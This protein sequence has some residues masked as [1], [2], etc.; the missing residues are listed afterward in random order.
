MVFSRQDRRR[1]RQGNEN[2]D[3]SY[4][5]E[6][7]CSISS[8][9]VAPTRLK[10]MAPFR[11][12]ARNFHS[13]QYRRKLYRP[14]SGSRPRGS[15]HPSKPLRIVGPSFPQNSRSA[16]WPISRSGWPFRTT[17]LPNRVCSNSQKR[18]QLAYHSTP[19]QDSASSQAAPRATSTGCFRSQRGG[20]IRDRLRESAAPG[21]HPCE[22]K[23]CQRPSAHRTHG[24]YCP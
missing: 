5:R 8:R 22:H 10:R 6:T 12:P 4:R 7:N 18:A 17:P 16:C 11:F 1:I 2:E 3:A 9:V 14:A 15:G 13:L 20:L 23:E 21:K 24:P 19:S